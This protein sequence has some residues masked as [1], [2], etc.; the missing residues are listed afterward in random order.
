MCNAL[1]DHDTKGSFAAL[2]HLVFNSKNNQLS[3]L[4]FL[5]C[6]IDWS[7]LEGSEY[8]H[9]LYPPLIWMCS[10]LVQAHYLFALQSRSRGIAS[11]PPHR[12]H[13]AC[14]ET[15][16]LRL[17]V[18]HHYFLSLRCCYSL[19]PS[20]K[21]IASSDPLL[22]YFRWYLIATNKWQYSTLMWQLYLYSRYLLYRTTSA[23]VCFPF[24]CVKMN[25]LLLRVCGGGRLDTRPLTSWSRK[26][27]LVGNHTYW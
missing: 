16:W 19:F 14:S 20:T 24:L 25:C 8:V 5:I 11:K 15:L 22:M 21:T 12:L 4:T 2:S 18:H 6:L 27:T 3:V 7:L 17:L 13:I 9:H 1:E 23:F 10:L 26:N